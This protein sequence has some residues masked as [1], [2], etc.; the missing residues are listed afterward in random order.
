MIPGVRPLTIPPRRKPPDHWHA[1]QATLP[2][3]V[4]VWHQTYLATCQPLDGSEAAHLELFGRLPGVLLSGKVILYSLGGTPQYNTLRQLE[5][6][7]RE[8]CSFERI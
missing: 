1:V 5:Q 2:V 6:R 7:E 8:Q 4:L 3:A